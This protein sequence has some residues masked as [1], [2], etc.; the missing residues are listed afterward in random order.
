MIPSHTNLVSFSSYCDICSLAELCLTIHVKIDVRGDQVDHMVHRIS[1][2][3]PAI[4]PLCLGHNRYGEQDT[5]SKSESD[6]QGYCLNGV[7]QNFV[8]LRRHTV[9]FPRRSRT[10]STKG[11]EHC[12]LVK[13]GELGATAGMN[14]L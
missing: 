6:V 1:Q 10:S 8:F 4:L 11:D 9:Q 12:R 2:K 14:G 13:E 7:G 5:A 3:G